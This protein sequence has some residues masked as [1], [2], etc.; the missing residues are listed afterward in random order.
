MFVLL[1]RCFFLP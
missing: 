1:F